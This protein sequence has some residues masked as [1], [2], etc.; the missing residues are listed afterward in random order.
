ML[1]DI[2]TFARF[3]FV[4][5]DAETPISLELPSNIHTGKDMF[6]FCMDLL[7]KGLVLLYGTGNRVCVD[8]LT[9]EQ[10]NGL[11]KR[12]GLMGVRCDLAVTP[13][14]SPMDM[15]EIVRRVGMLYDMPD[16]LDVSA[17][18]FQIASRDALFEIRFA[19]FHNV[20]SRCHG[21]AVTR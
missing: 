9:S 17:Y 8:A 14:Q 15:Q 11:N 19:L 5:H 18:S 6:C 2:D 12:L 7:C 1:L 4:E 3:L 13:L 16:N 21:P 10:F 20:S